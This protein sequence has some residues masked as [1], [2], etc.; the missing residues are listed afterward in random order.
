[1]PLYEHA[2]QAQ[3]FEAVSKVTQYLKDWDRGQGT[4]PVSP[5][6]SWEAGHRG[7]VRVRGKQRW[8]N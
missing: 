7:M 6:E 1:M 3:R 4:E 8:K 5:R 2:P